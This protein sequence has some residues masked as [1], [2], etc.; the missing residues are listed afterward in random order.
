MKQI[1]ILL[2]DDHTLV[3]EAW[4]CTLNSDPR[5]KIIAEAS[6]AEEAVE[7]ASKLHPDIIVMDINLPGMNGIEAV[8]RL[9]QN[10]PGSKILGVSLHTQPA[11]ARRM[12]QEGAMGYLTKSSSKEELF[13]SILEIKNERKYVCW[14]IKNK[15]SEQLLFG[16]DT[17]PYRTLSS[18]ER[19]IVSYLKN[20]NSSKEIADA[21]NISVKTVEVYRHRIL[22]KLNLKNTAAVVNFLHNRQPMEEG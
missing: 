15:L 17:S 19:S 8:K 14:E 6:S 1:T 12:M 16:E 4:Q 18:R 21:E 22:K 3:R 20:G 10:A 2:T 9:R 13:K 11:Y 5:F 7:L